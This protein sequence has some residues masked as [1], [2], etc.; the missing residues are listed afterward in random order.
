MRRLIARFVAGA[1]TV[2]GLAFVGATVP[3]AHAASGGCPTVG[4]KGICLSDKAHPPTPPDAPGGGGTESAG[5]T[6]SGDGVCRDQGKVIPC[7]KDGFTWMSSSTGGCYGAMLDAAPDSPM[8]EGHDPSEG[9]LGYC[10]LDGVSQVTFFVPNGA[11]PQIVDA[12]A[13]AQRMLARAP[14]EVADVQMA[15][16]YGFNTYIRI[17]NWFWVPEAQWHNVNLTEDVGPA[18]VTLTAEPSRLVIDTGDNPPAPIG[19]PDAGRPWRDGMSNAAQTTCSYAYE[20][21]KNPSGDTYN[22]SGRIYYEVSWTCAGLC[23]APA[24]ALGEYP[25]PE[26]EEHPVE[27]RQRQTVVTQ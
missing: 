3:L 18:S 19:C 4:A 8:W 22:I 14:F 5:T 21:I 25:A 1:L 6:G 24:G 26:G 2:V 17:E 27:V 13:V 16:P 9:S 11:A 23:S 20:S 10:P 15:P 7:S 12:A